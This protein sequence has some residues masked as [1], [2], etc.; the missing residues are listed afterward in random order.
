VGVTAR[1]AGWSSRAAR[2]RALNRLR[3]RRRR[4]EE[5]ARQAWQRRELDEF[6][7]A[8]VI[9]VPV[10]DVRFAGPLPAATAPAEGGSER[11]AGPAGV[12]RRGLAQRLAAELIEAP[13]GIP[14]HQTVL[15]HDLLSAVALT[16]AVSRL[17]GVGRALSLAPVVAQKSP[18]AALVAAGKGGKAVWV[19]GDTFSVVFRMSPVAPVLVL[20]DELPGYAVRVDTDTDRDARNRVQ[21]MVFG[22][23]VALGQPVSA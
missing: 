1:R 18:G 2:A 23:L 9:M 3:Q 15:G 19:H 16:V 5:L 13:G 11:P 8:E 7:N 21:A 6:E 20:L 22:V 14:G 4:R 10:H 12:G 17:D